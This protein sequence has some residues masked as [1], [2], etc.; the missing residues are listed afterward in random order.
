MKALIVIDKVGE[1]LDDIQEALG[2]KPLIT[3]KDYNDLIKYRADWNVHF[4]SKVVS[5]SE[6]KTE[7]QYEFIDTLAIVEAMISDVVNNNDVKTILTDKI[8]KKL[9]P[10]IDTTNYNILISHNISWSRYFEEN[11]EGDWVFTESANVLTN[12]IKNKAIINKTVE[13]T[14]ENT[15]LLIPAPMYSQ[16]LGTECFV[17]VEGYDENPTDKNK[18]TIYWL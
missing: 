2:K 5:V 6:T 8:K 9:K 3:A 16:G 1:I 12:M 18:K 14:I 10:I 4:V 7:T 11:S 17:V 13:Q 15:N